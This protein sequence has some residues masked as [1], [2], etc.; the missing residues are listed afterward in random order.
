MK[1]QGS[2]FP[3]VPCPLTPAAPRT[4]FRSPHQGQVWQSV[5][6]TCLQFPAQITPGK[7]P[8]ACRGF[9][10][11]ISVIPGSR[12]KIQFCRSFFFFPSNFVLITLITASLD[13]LIPHWSHFSLQ[14]AYQQLGLRFI[15]NKRAFPP[16]PPSFMPKLN[17]H[18][19]KIKQKQLFESPLITPIIFVNIIILS[20]RWQLLSNVAVRLWTSCYI[21]LENCFNAYAFR[22]LK[23]TMALWA[24]QCCTFFN[25]IVHLFF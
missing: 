4:R 6:G 8:M 24:I 9:F 11:Q 14:L 7:T 20:W 23:S 1:G 25:L 21:R 3:H 19:K 12:K 16:F 13:C 10:P 18:Y 15:S 5:R 2:F 17:L 22:G